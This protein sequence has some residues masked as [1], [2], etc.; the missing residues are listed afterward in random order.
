M[1]QYIQGVVDYIPMIQPFQPDFNLFQNV[2]QLKDSQYKAGYNKLSALYGTLLNSPM[3]REENVELRNT[4]FTDI[5]AQI[6]KISSLD[7]SKTQNVDAAYKVFQPLIDNDYIVKDMAYT[8][9]AYNQLKQA[10]NFRNCTNE[11]ECGGKYWEG[12]VR[13]IQYQMKDFSKATAEESLGFSAPRYTPAVNVAEK[14]MKFAKDM[15]F[16]MQSVTWTKDGRYQVTTKN[17]TQMIPSLTK[18]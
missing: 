13:A 6:Q 10:D 8:K 5:S 16:N 3:L 9:Q 14:A 12:G 11:K 18:S 4:F 15:G 17:G 7:L 2:L 1:S